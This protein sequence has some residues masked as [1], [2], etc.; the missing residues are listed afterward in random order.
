[1][2]IYKIT[3]KINNKIYIGQTTKTINLRWQ[4]HCTDALSNRTNTKFAKAIRKYGKDNFIVE[5]IDT[6]QN[7]EELNQ[8][9][10][11]WINYYN[12]FYNGYNQTKGGNQPTVQNKIDNK[13][14]VKIYEDLK[15]IYLTYDFLSSKYNISTGLLSKINTGKRY[16]N[17][18]LD[19][20]L[21]NKKE[22]LDK[23]CID[24]GKKLS[25]YRWTRCSEC[26]HKVRRIPL[27]D[28]PITREELK[29]KIR[30]MT[31]VD[32]GKEFN[33]NDNSI[34]KWYDKFNLPRTKKEIKKYTDEE[35]VNI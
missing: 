32:I 13:T 8:K 24:C 9:E 7:K 29:Q 14:I 31:F 28:M 11:Y 30:K 26:S 19:Y 22:H 6:A 35:W 23:Y 4:R 33:I 16:F 2:Y 1:M 27:E 34:R 17:E 15:N 20:P 21:R 3:N 10:I 12:T 18:N 25:D 5:K